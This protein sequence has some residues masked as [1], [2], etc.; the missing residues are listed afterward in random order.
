MAFIEQHYVKERGLS[1][2]NTVDFLQKNYLSQ[3]KLGLKSSEGGLYPPKQK[4]AAATAESSSREPH[5]YV[6]DNG[7]SQPLANKAPADILKSGR[8]LEISTDGKKSHPILEKTSLVLPDG[9]DYSASTNRLYWTNMGI[10]GQND[11]SVMSSNLDGTDV[12]TILAPGSAHTPK[13]MT[14]DETSRKLYFS[15]REGLRVFRCNLDG[16]ALEPLIRNGDWQDPADG[17]DATKWCVGIAVSPR[18]G[19]FYWTQKGPSKGG[20]GRIFS[21]GIQTPEGETAGSR[22]D[23]TCLLDRLPEPIDLEIDEETATLFWT[24]RGEVPFGN[25][26]NQI[27]LDEAGG[28]VLGEGLL[29]HSIIAQNFDEA[30][31]LRI[32]RRSKSIYVSDLGG[33]VWKCNFDGSGKVKVFEDKSCA[34]TGLVVV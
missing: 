12:Q 11:G 4:P 24:D 21:A 1:T 27:A 8:I 18:H 31:G 6:L 14:I 22:S 16:S 32:E 9:I 23:V 5:I 19:R 13:Q 29:K 10:I 3:G 15:D 33:T 7:L 26:L 20:R 2:E 17:S 25:T 30:I 34:F 28:V